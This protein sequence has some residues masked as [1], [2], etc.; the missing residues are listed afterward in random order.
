MNIINELESAIESIYASGYN[1]FAYEGAQVKAVSAMYDAK[2][3]ELNRYSKEAKRHFKAGEYT[4]C[5]KAC[6]KALALINDIEKYIVSTMN[7]EEFKK[8]AKY[9]NIK[10]VITSVLGAALIVG[11]L[12]VT[13]K[14]AIE[15]HKKNKEIMKQNESI[16]SNAMTKVVNDSINERNKRQMRENIKGQVRVNVVGAAGIGMAV[17]NIKEYAKDI[18]ENEQVNVNIVK[19]SLNASKQVFEGLKKS[20]NDAM[21]GVRANESDVYDI[22]LFASESVIGELVEMGLTDDQV[23]EVY[24]EYIR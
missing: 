11:I 4:E 13:N 23:Y 10:T 24:T 16:K 20:A 8:E 1:E 3:K 22:E 12:F 5:I 15:T 18:K 2:C 9:F 6:D 19:N 14:S 21:R 17:Y 7:T